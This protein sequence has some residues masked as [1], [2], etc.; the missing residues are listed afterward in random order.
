MYNNQLIGQ[1][2][3]QF[4]AAGLSPIKQAKCNNTYNLDN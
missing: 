3:Q 1:A 2:P 4:N